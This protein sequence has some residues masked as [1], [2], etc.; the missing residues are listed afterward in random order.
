MSV[1]VF[2]VIVACAISVS[3]ILG[4]TGRQEAAKKIVS[5]AGLSPVAKQLVKEFNALPA[6]YRPF[7]DIVSVVRDL[8]AKHA[9]DAVERDNHFNGNWYDLGGADSARFNNGFAYRFTWGQGRK[10]NNCYHTSDR[11]GRCKFSDYG[12]LHAA[13]KAVEKS[14]QDK[15]RVILHSRYSDSSDTVKQ[16]E[17]RLRAEAGLNETFIRE[18]KELD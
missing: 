1:V 7:D 8:D 12:D 4:R 14:I 2:F 11:Y 18:F 3:V 15:E 13:I 10:Y 9:A 16:L 5:T 17:E 6:E